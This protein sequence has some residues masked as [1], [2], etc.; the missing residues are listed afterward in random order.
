MWIVRMGIGG[1]HN[2]AEQNERGIS[3]IVFFQDRIKRNVFTV[4]TELTIRHIEYDAVVDLVPLCVVWQKNKLRIR[5]H[6]LFDKP[7]AGDAVYFNFLASDPLPFFFFFKRAGRFPPCRRFW[8]A[9]RRLWPWP[10]F[11]FFTKRHRGSVLLVWPSPL[12]GCFC[13]ANNRC[14]KRD[15]V[16]VMP[17][18]FRLGFVS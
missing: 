14:K 8:L 16:R 2:F 4:M 3:E 5:V 17:H 1:A 10:A 7:R 12:S 11:Y 6:K 9:A 13:S 18:V 15:C